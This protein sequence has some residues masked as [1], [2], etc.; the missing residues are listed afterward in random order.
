MMLRLGIDGVTWQSYG[1]NLEEKL[2]V[3]HDQ[4]APWQLSSPSGQ[5][6]ATYRRPMARNGR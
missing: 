6:G 1:E 2:K 3:L 4:G 5:S